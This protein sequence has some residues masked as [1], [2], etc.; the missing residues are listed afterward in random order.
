MWKQKGQYS[1][2]VRARD[3]NYDKKAN[4]KRMQMKVTNHGHEK[5][6]EESQKISHVF[7]KTWEIF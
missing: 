3:E 6:S 5:M 2:Y 1:Y 4:C 7:W